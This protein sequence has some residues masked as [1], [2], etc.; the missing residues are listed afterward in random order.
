MYYGAEYKLLKPANED[1]FITSLIGTLKNSRG[2][3]KGTLHSDVSVT[4]E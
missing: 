1:H 3:Y 2:T 4:I